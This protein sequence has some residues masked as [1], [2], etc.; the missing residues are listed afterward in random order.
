MSHQGYSKS[1][2]QTSRGGI[3][4]P[5]SSWPSSGVLFRKVTTVICLLLLRQC[6][7]RMEEAQF[8]WQ[9]QGR[10]SKK[11][12]GNA[13]PHWQSLLPIRTS[14]THTFTRNPLLLSLAD[15]G[16]SHK[17]SGSLS[18]VLL[19]HFIFFFLISLLVVNELLKLQ[20]HVHQ[21]LYPTV[22]N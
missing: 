15:L 22:N 2:I 21:G 10:V 13:L 18:L 20:I 19:S 6:L 7:C 12:D 11:S 5:D 17:P 9:G 14:C 3:Y 16:V 8:Q 1:L 4:Q